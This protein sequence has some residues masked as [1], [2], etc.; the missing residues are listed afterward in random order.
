MIIKKD[1]FR[2]RELPCTLPWLSHL[3]EGKAY[4]LS[5]SEAREVDGMATEIFIEAATNVRQT[6]NF[7]TN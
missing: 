2:L 5:E 3:M 6:N 4:C 7:I 1:F